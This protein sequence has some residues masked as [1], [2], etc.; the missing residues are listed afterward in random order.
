MGKARATGTR[1]LSLDIEES[2]RDY[3]DAFCDDRK[4]KKR[5]VVEAALTKY[6]ADPPQPE[7]PVSLPP[8]KPARK[9][10]K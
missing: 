9:K 10:K 6:F 3:L 4:A 5:A 2:L 8:L 7:T 1:Q